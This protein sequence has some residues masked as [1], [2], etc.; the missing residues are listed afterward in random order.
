MYPSALARQYEPNDPSFDDPNMIDI[1]AAFNADAPWWFG[2]VEDDQG[3]SISYEYQTRSQVDGYSWSFWSQQPGDMPP[4][5]KKVFDLEQVVMHELMHGLGIISSWYEWIG[6]DTLVPGYPVLSEPTTSNNFSGISLSKSYIFDKFLF[7]SRAGI[8]MKSYAAGIRQEIW[9]IGKQIKPK[10][11]SSPNWGDYPWSNVSML[12]TASD[13]W[14]L[15]SYIRQ[16]TAVT[17]RGL[18]FWYPA[19]NIRQGSNPIT[20]YSNYHWPKTTG[21][22]SRWRY[23]VLYTPLEYSGGSSISHL[24]ASFYSGTAEYLMRPFGTSGT[25]VDNFTPQNRYGPVGEHLL[26]IL[27]ALGYVTAIGPFL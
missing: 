17:P 14:K 22:G 4:Y 8:W 25:A 2:G 26:G 20:R 21:K 23:A 16:V 5:K 7:D 10:T 15:A 13:G 6:G 27:R 24:D 18:S 12:F 1:S 11:P 19:P 9:K 3:E